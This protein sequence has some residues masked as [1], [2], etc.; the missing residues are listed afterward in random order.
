MSIN[1]RSVFVA[2]RDYFLKLKQILSDSVTVPDSHE[3]DANVRDLVRRTERLTIIFQVVRSGLNQTDIPN[4]NKFGYRRLNLVDWIILLTSLA[5]LLR[6][7]VLIFNADEP[8]A[9]YLGDSLF[10]SKD[11]LPYLTLIAMSILMMA[12]VREWILYLEAKGELKVLSIWKDYRDGCD[13]DKFCMNRLKIRRFRFSIYLVSLIYCNVMI[14]A[15]IFTATAFF[16]PLLTNPW[17]YKIPR[18]AIYG[19]IW[20]FSLIITVTY[21]L[22]SLF[23]FGWFILCTF[24]FHLFRLLDLLDRA[25]FL[26]NNTNASIYTEKDVRSFCLLI[27]S[28]LNSFEL[29][30]FKLRYVLLYSVFAFSLF[31]DVFIFLGAIIRIYNDTLA[32]LITIFGIIVLSIFGIS[33]LILGNFITKLYNL[34][35]RLHQ[36]TIMR[37]FS[38]N[39]MSKV[40]E[41]MNRVAGPYNG[42]KIGDFLTVDKTFFILF[43]LENISILM[44]ITVNVRP[45]I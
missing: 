10:R 27:I 32:N 3:F 20:A 40:W 13:L 21:L 5:N 19:T 16:I 37:N 35:I 33:G 8:L 41:I 31:N 28:R 45:L 43:V 38:L 26:L 6:I 30:S 4:V 9:F 25:S 34:T 23:G 29:A 12:P 17:T 18:L 14:M 24:S 44:L 11:R 15:P 7:F 1:E 36:I 42:V 39:T 22:N 2:I